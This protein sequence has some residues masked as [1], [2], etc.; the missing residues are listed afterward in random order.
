[1]NDYH[2]ITHFYFQKNNYNIITKCHFIR[3]IIIFYYIIIIN[4]TY[5]KYKYNQDYNILSY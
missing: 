3:Y 4:L 5:Y 1:M 2:L